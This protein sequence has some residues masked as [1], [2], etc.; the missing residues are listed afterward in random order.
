M[1]G[2][3]TVEISSTNLQGSCMYPQLPERKKNDITHLKTYKIVM[4]KHKQPK[5]MV[6]LLPPF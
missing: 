4:K 1:H 5:G 6:K 2:P 3:C